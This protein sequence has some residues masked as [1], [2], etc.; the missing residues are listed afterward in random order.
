MGF[1][2]GISSFVKEHSGAIHGV[3]DVAG[4]I[5]GVGAVADM[6]NAAI[7]AAEGDWM[8]AASSVVS[9]IPGVGDTMALASKSA[10]A[11]KAG[12]KGMKEMSALSKAKGMKKM[13][14]ALRGKAKTGAKKA[15]QKLKDLWGKFKNLF[16]RK[17]TGDKCFTGDTPVFTSRG[18]RPI[19]EMQKGDDIY[20][21]D[22]K[23]GETGIQ[24]VEEV[25][26]TGTHT[27]Y[28][29]WLDGEEEIKTTAYHPVYVKEQGW[30]SAINL[31]EGDIVETMDGPAQI[32]KIV[33]VRHEEKVPTYN[34]HVK[35]WASYFVGEARVYVHNGKGH[36]DAAT[37]V[38]WPSKPHRNGTEGHWEAI[39]EEVE[40]MKD[41]GQYS[42]IYVNKGLSHE[43][44]GAT[45]NRRPDIMAVR[46][47]NGLIDQVEVPSKT[48]TT[49]AL[50]ERMRDNQRIMGDRA[51]SIKIKRIRGG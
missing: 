42:K 11:A 8:N 45:P 16:K 18:Y 14:G 10:K 5:P 51:G 39:T 28:H 38:I 9:A 34:L 29:I 21:R 35:E 20:S 6:A 4:F 26:C 13:L 40:T 2:S 46:R 47:D 27:V 48:D 43:I 17:C 32:T 33:K 37:E 12:L 41:S 30:V 31:R 25:F 3:L 50:I 49:D 1:L 24:E 19:R 22:E 23:T 44:P 15:G 36:P 7:Y